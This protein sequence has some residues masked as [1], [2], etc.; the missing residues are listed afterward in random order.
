MASL[1]AHIDRLHAQ[2]N[3]WGLFHFLSPY[4]T[5]PFS[6]GYTPVLDS[7]LDPFKGLNSKTAKV[8]SALVTRLWNLNFWP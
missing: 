6:L 3:E 2:L 4:L 1:E 8:N 5:H 7:E